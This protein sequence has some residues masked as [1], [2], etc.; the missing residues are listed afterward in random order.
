MVS[1]GCLLSE[2]TGKKACL[3]GVVIAGSVP[4][5]MNPKKSRSK[6]LKTAHCASQLSAGNTRR[7]D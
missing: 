3:G 2:K 4:V 6:K 1:P 5:S 7:V